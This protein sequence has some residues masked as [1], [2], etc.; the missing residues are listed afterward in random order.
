MSFKEGAP[1]QLLSGLLNKR[2]GCKLVSA[3]C[4]NKSYISYDRYLRQPAEKQT[5]AKKELFLELSVR[6]SVRFWLAGNTGPGNLSKPLGAQI[7]IPLDV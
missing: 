4:V 7:L 3:F 2:L 5:K 6:I 1:R